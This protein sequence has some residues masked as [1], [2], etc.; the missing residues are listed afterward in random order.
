MNEARSTLALCV[1]MLWLG[2]GS[3]KKTDAENAMPP[4]QGTGASTAPASEPSSGGTPGSVPASTSGGSG[5]VDAGSSAGDAGGA[6]PPVAIACAPRAVAGDA[7][8]HFHH[9]H[10]NTVDPEMDLE[11]FNKY[12]GA[13]PIDFCKDA[14]SG[15]VTKATKTDRAYFLYTMVAKAPDPT[16]NTYLE[17][18][19]WIN[20]DPNGELKRMV[21][22]GATLF[23]EGRAQ[24]PEAFKGTACGAMLG[25]GPYWF[26]LQAPSG[27]RIEVA[28]G[29]GP[30]MTGFGHVHMIMGVDLA[31][32][33]TVTKSAYKVGNA[34]A[35][36][37]IDMVNHTD[38]SLL[39]SILAMETVVETRGK[40]ID[41]I[42]YSTTDLEAA[43]K[44]IMDAGIKI[45]EDTSFKSD[46]GF[47]SFF[48]KDKKGI[49]VEVVE[50]TAFAP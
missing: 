2:C 38:V 26:Y 44:R 49:W 23:P 12:L 34:I 40:P 6:V 42:A 35:P 13:A 15:A 45:E 41:H 1:L 28:K 4:A 18:V 24:C 27:A 29:P 20:Q 17:H 37:A 9:V 36:G 43:K 33:A 39:E 25:L 30:A 16:L 32:Y 21:N 22:L 46:Y 19:G 50:D 14:T 31:W 7:T 11:F 5:S 8:M 3:N 47:K 48:L 10:F